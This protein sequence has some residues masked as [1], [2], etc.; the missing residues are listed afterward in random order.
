MART[1]APG[2][3]TLAL[4]EVEDSAKG[5]PQAQGQ[6][7]DGTWQ[8][9][10]IT[11]GLSYIPKTRRILLFLRLRQGLNSGLDTGQGAQTNGWEK[12]MVMER[13]KG[14]VNVTENVRPALTAH[15][16]RGQ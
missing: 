7:D 10:R 14:E 2:C 1:Q 15:I 12:G 6:A 13:K 8:S 3:F 16:Q 11:W 9:R 4:S 5:Q